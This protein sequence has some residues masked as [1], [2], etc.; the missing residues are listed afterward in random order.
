MHTTASIWIEVWS[1]SVG[2]AKGSCA[3][4][5]RNFGLHFQPLL[6]ISPTKR[7]PSDPFLQN[8]GDKNHPPSFGFSCWNYWSTASL[9]AVSHGS[10]VAFRLLVLCLITLITIDLSQRFELA[11]TTKR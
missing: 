4:K 7:Q 5:T 1:T 11:G 3:V 9:T 2:M 10:H 6:L 8:K